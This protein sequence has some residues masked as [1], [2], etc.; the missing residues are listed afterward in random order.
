MDRILNAGDRAEVRSVRTQLLRD[1]GFAVEEAATGADALR[2]AA[3]RPPSLVLL[4]AGLR[5][6]GR[7]SWWE[8]V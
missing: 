3:E 7:A 1:A 4:D 5:E 6:I 8:R 2:L